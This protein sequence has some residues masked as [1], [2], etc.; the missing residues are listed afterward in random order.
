V[1]GF[2]DL[3]YNLIDL[4]FHRGKT[5]D[6]ENPLCVAALTR[7]AFS[8]ELILNIEREGGKKGR[9]KFF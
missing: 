7:Q 1:I 4:G 9:R 8:G 5:V 2:K 6:H 3:F